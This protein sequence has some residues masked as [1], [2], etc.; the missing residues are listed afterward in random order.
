MQIVEYIFFDN[1]GYETSQNGKQN[2]API[3]YP[4]ALILNIV[5]IL[6]LLFFCNVRDIFSKKC[7]FCEFCCKK[8]KLCCKE[9]EVARKVAK[10]Y[11]DFIEV[12]IQESITDRFPV[13]L[14]LKTG[15]SYVGFV[16]ESQLTAMPMPHDVDIVLLPMLSGYRK[17]ET[18]E[19]EFKTNYYLIYSTESSTESDLKKFRI[20]IPRS[21]LV[22]VRQ[23]D[24][25]IYKKFQSLKSNN[26]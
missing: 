21:A 25:E 15:K 2:G 4:Y 9:I 11:G 1:D 24:I 7:E 8:C 5:I 18:R 17:E 6:L 19:L 13:E 3:E 14:S 12:F 16:M 23:F 10:K 22:S 26:T 20:V